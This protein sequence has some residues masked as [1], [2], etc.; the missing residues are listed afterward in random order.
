MNRFVALVGVIS[1]LSACDGTPKF[2][3]ACAELGS[4]LKIQSSK[5]VDILRSVAGLTSKEAV[6]AEKKYMSTIRLIES[7]SERR[8]SKYSLKARSQECIKA[9]ADLI[10]GFCV[11]A[12]KVSTGD[13]DAT[14]HSLAAVVR[15]DKQCIL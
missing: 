3:D 7:I 5:R 1:I 13:R 2:E 11:R 14:T 4:T 9:E 6:E 12:I 15:I 10:D 8:E